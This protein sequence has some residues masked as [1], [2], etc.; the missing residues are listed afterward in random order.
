M[1][2]IADVNVIRVEKILMSLE[3][4]RHNTI[5]MCN[6]RLAAL[7]TFARFFLVG[8][9]PQ[10]TNSVLVKLQNHYKSNKQGCCRH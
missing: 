7:H 9:S 1:L 10:E 2:D 6:A 5:A 4:E 8:L 3:R